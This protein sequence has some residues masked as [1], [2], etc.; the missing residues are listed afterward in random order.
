MKISIGGSQR[1]WQSWH[2]AKALKASAARR[3]GGAKKMASKL[4][5]KAAKGAQKNVE[6]SS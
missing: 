3:R 4:K 1:K 2:L 6:T 5:A